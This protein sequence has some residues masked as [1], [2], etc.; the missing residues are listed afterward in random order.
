MGQMHNWY[1]YIH[2]TTGEPVYNSNGDFSKYRGPVVDYFRCRESLWYCLEIVAGE[3]RS[4]HSCKSSAVSGKVL[5]RHEQFT[6]LT[7]LK[8]SMSSLHCFAELDD[9]VYY[10]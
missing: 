3:A 5:N 2:M 9:I 8:V 10:Y 6:S 4:S 7:E 1:F